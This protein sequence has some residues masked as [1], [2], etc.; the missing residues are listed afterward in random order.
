[1]VASAE[2]FAP[3][4]AESEPKT[5]VW[6]FFGPVRDR[7]GETASQVVDRDW[8]ITF[9]LYDSRRGPSLAR[10]GDLLAGEIRTHEVKGGKLHG[11]ARFYPDDPDRIDQ[12]L[13]ANGFSERTIA[14]GSGNRYIVF[15]GGPSGG[16]PFLG[17]LTGDINRYSDIDTYKKPNVVNGYV[18]VSR[19]FSKDQFIE[20]LI[21]NTAD[22]NAQR[23]NYDLFPS[24]GSN[25][26]NSNSYFRGLVESAGGSVS[27]SPGLDLPGFYKPVP[28]AQFFQP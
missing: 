7:V 21:L 17:E 6:D 16:P 15:S 18:S 26:Y 12:F 19:F 25:G 28:S 10:S 3:E 27:L 13:A 20:N 4:K 1:M 14:D 9:R 5:R 24:S 8:E 22:Y 11:S 2:S 23:V